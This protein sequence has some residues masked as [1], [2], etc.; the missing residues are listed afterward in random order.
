M[1][2]YTVL[3]QPNNV[4]VTVDAGVTLLQ[5]Q[6]EAGLHPDAPAAVR[7]PAENAKS[8]WG[9]RRFSPAKP[10]LTGIWSLPFP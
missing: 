4:S 7:A 6:I 1:E 2:R 9:G 10:Q 8:H 3:F 5:A